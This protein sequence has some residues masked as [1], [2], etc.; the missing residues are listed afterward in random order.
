L[1][2][3]IKDVRIEK[4]SYTFSSLKLPEK[5]NSPKEGKSSY[6]FSHQGIP[7]KESP[8]DEIKKSSPPPVEI[9]EPP[10]GQFHDAWGAM[11]FK[12]KLN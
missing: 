3:K 8:V 5:L 7:K 2:K 12:N 11:F 9:H 10:L 6:R 1:P 4:A